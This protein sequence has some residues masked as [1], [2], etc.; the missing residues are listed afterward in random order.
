[1]R[2]ESATSRPVLSIG[3]TLIDII[4]TDGAPSLVEARDFVARA[5]GAPANVAVA[6]ARLGLP[7]AFCG[8]VGADPLGERLIAELGAQ[9]VDTARL[10]QT[11]A[12]PTTIAFAWKDARGDG[13]FWLMRGADLDLSPEDADR[14][15]ITGLA[16]L[17][18]GSVSLAAA[19]SRAAV[20]HAVELANAADVPVV[21]DV[22]LRPTVWTNPADALPICERVIRSSTLVKLSLDDAIGLF[23]ADISPEAACARVLALGT[24]SVVLTD[25]ARGC[26]F[27]SQPDGD[28]HVVPA[29]A[30]DAVEPTGAGD[31]FAAGLIARLIA[32]GWQPP[33]TDDVAFAAAAGALA[34]TRH[35]AWEGLPDQARLEAFLAG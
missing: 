3:E 18:L 10:R 5:G 17:V 33:R 16:A 28:V 35:G 12:A 31:A 14:A 6:L 2:D 11:A 21:F 19:S 7:S 15:G 9:G 29:F 34:T 22:N 20:L 13:H 25:G 32:S 30:V 8:V 24:P 27:A 23:G 26:W 4:A 1:M